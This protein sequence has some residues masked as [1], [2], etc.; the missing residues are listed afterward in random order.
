MREPRRY[1]KES[2]RKRSDRIVKKLARKRGGRATPNSGATKIKGDMI[3]KAFLIE[4]K[5][6]DKNSY[7]ITDEVWQKVVDE[8]FMAQKEPALEVETT[9]SHYV[10]VPVHV[11]EQI[12]EQINGIH[13]ELL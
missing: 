13:K 4:H 5:F 2:S 9:S 7:R 6:T 11:F 3:V 10:V 12:L 8:A 1:G